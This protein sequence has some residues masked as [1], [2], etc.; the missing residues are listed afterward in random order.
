MNPYLTDS[1]DWVYILTIFVRSRSFVYPIVI[2]TTERC[3]VKHN[4]VLFVKILTLPDTGFHRSCCILFSKW[5]YM[6]FLFYFWSWWSLVFFYLTE[7]FNDLLLSSVVISSVQ[8]WDLYH[9]PSYRQRRFVI[10]F[11]SFL[12]QALCRRTS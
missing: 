3:L 6:L 10:N 4:A 5:C 2:R 9:A 7:N 11:L 8:K 1:T 12:C